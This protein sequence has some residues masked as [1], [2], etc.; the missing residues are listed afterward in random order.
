VMAVLTYTR[1]LAAAATALTTTAPRGGSPG[2]AAVAAFAAAAAVALDD[3][4]SATAEGR[5]PA[6]LPAGLDRGGLTTE[7]EGGIEPLLRAQLV[8][9]GRQLATLHS[10]LTRIAGGAAAADAATMSRPSA[11]TAA[12]GS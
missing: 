3:L 5:L 10:A 7:A 8:R 6:P 12:A 11:V 4:S 9:A 2:S 1:R